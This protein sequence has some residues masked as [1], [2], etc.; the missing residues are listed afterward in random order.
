MRFGVKPITANQTTAPNTVRIK[1]AHPGFSQLKSQP[2]VYR[3]ELWPVVHKIKPEH[4]DYSGT[5]QL[6]NSK[7]R[8]LVW[9][10]ANGSLGLRLEKISDQDTKKE[11][12]LK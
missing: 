3:C 5:L 11:T 2:E 4:A 6:T 9:V 8:I 1:G 12:G 10:H 7:A